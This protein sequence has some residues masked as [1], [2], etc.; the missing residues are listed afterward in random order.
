MRDRNHHQDSKVHHCLPSSSYEMH[1]SPSSIEPVL[2]SLEL[3]SDS[4]EGEQLS[5]NHT[6]E[7]EEQLCHIC[8]CNKGGPTL[9]TSGVHICHDIGDESAIVDIMWRDETPSTSS[10]KLSFRVRSYDPFRK[11]VSQWCTEQ[12][13][14]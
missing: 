5:P 1:S 2:A 3:S 12:Y 10:V 11:E 8:L 7:K 14:V 9:P 6:L 4:S 13:R